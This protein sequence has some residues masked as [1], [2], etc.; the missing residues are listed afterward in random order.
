MIG[1]LHWELNTLYNL[2]YNII[3]YMETRKEYLEKQYSLFTNELKDIIGEIFF[4]HLK[5]LI[6]LIYLLIFK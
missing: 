5:M 3:L 4:H 1:L 6:L 2:I